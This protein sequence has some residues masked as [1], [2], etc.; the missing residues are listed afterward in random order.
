MV[1]EHLQQTGYLD[2]EPL[3]QAEH[4]VKKMK[5][6]EVPD[7]SKTFLSEFGE[8]VDIVDKTI[9]SKIR[10]GNMEENTDLTYNLKANFS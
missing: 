5:A 10:Q 3:V 1:E 6:I 4:F 2:L 8:S 9:R 7:R